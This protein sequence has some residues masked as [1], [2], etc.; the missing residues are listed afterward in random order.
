MRVDRRNLWALEFLLE[1]AE[2]E[3]TW[4][5]AVKL[6][7]MIQKI[8]NIQDKSQLGK[9]QVYEGMDKLEGGDRKGAF[10]A[11]KKSN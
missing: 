8:R 3:R 10:A 9:F 2:K 5:Q 1:I 4:A 11:L 6:I 7:K